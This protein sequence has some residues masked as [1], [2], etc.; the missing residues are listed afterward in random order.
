MRRQEH[1][2]VETIKDIVYRKANTNDKEYLY[3]L[4]KSL[5]TSFDVNE[6]DFLDVF[7]SLLDDENVDLIVA[8]KEQKLIGYVLVFHHSAFYANGL[9]SWVEE[10]FVLEQ[11]RRMHIGKHLMEEVEKLSKE[12]VS[13]LVAL[14]T[15]RADKF[16]RSIGYSESATYFKKTF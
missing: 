4:A 2:N 11:Y 5:A 12:R 9:I 15:R 3:V 6:F 8:E 14:A 13:K 7:K 10:L 16:Y 1:I